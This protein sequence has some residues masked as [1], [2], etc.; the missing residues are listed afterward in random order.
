MAEL[1]RK[2]VTAGGAQPGS[3]LV[4]RTLRS[5]AQLLLARRTASGGGASVLILRTVAARPGAALRER[6]RH[7]YALRERLD[8]GWAARPIHLDLDADHPALTLT[9][10]GGELLSRR[11]GGP[12][13]VRA[14]LRV[15][16]GM[17]AALG[18]LH[19]RGLI[20]K[21]IQPGH[22]FVDVAAARA[23]L[24][25]FGLA[26][27]LP[28][29]QAS[30]AASDIIAGTLRYM[31]PEQTGRMNRSVDARSDLYA[32]GATFYE[33]LTGVAPF[34]VTDPAALMHAHLA[35]QPVAPGVRVPS[36]PGMLS[37]I[38]MKLLAKAAE[39]RYQTAAGLELDLRRCLSDWERQGSLDDF[40]LGT[41]DVPR[42]L[43]VPERLYG[44]EREVAALRAAF[45][46]VADQGRIELVLVH[47][48]AGI[49]KSSMVRELQRALLG[50]GGLFAAGK[51]DQYT[52]DVPLATLSQAL[53]GLLGMVIGRPEPER[54]V[55]QAALRTAVEPHGHFVAG[56][57][58][59]LES[60]IG[61]QPEDPEPS[62]Q[63]AP[64]RFHQVFRRFLQVFAQRAHPLVLFLDDLQWVD[65][66]TS[67]LL[68]QLLATPE[69]MHLLLVGA[70]RDGDGDGTGDAAPSH[71]PGVLARLEAMRGDGA[72][73]S[74][75]ALRPLDL[76]DIGWL[77]ADTLRT[78][79]HRV[80]ALAQ[81]VHERTGGNPFFTGQFIT[82]LADEQLLLY[83]ASTARWTWD[84]ARIDAL[85]EADPG[86]DGVVALMAQ[87]LRRL[88]AA[89]RAVLQQLACLGVQAETGALAT[90]ASCDADTLRA[91]LHP[92]VAAG[93][94]LQRQSLWVFSHDRVR[95]A[96]YA[97]IAPAARPRHHLQIARRM[98]AAMPSPD[99]RI[100]SV[101][102]IVDQLNRGAGAMTRQTEREQAAELNLMAAHRARRS[103]AYGSALGYLGAGIALL[104]DASWQR[105]HAM[106]FELHL[107][108]SECEL[109]AGLTAQAD[110]RLAGLLPRARTRIERAA[111]YRL[112]VV[113]HVLCS[114]YARAVAEA[115]ECLADFG[116]DLVPHPS[117]AQR[118]AAYADVL[119]RLGDRPIASL[120]ELPRAVDR[121]VEAAMAVLSELF[122]PACFT[123]ERL[124]FVHLCHMVR[125]SLS[126]GI[127]PG[128]AQ[129]FAWFGILLGR[130]YG[131]H[132]D[133]LQLA[134]LSQTLVTRHG[135]GAYEAKSLFSL[136]IAS[137]WTRP[138]EVAV[139]LARATFSTAAAQGD[140]AVACFA[141]HH[142]VN[143]LLLRGHPLDAVARDI[144]TGLAFVRKAGF[145]DVVDELLSQQRFVLALRGRTPSIKNW[146][147]DG[148]DTAAFEAALGPG[149]MPTMF[150]WH[151]LLRAQSLYIAGRP[152][153]A[154]DASLCAE[155]WLWSAVHVQCANQPYFAGLALAGLSDEEAA[156]VADRPQRLRGYRDQLAGWGSHAPATFADKVALLDAEIARL[157]RRPLDAGRLY[158][159]ATDLARTQGL[160]Q[161]EAIASELAAR[162]HAG[163]GLATVSE[164]YLRSARQ[165]YLRWGADAKVRQL[166]QTFAFLRHEPVTAGDVTPDFELSAERIDLAA[167]IRVSQALSGE[168]VLDRLIDTLLTAALGHAGAQR[169]LLVLADG[170]AW[171]VEAEAH[172][173]R[174]GE[175]V[176]VDFR[177]T[178]LAEHDM[179]TT[180]LQH[181]VRTRKR[182]LL[183]DAAVAQVLIP[184]GPDRLDDRA[185]RR[186]VLTLP[187]VRQ[188][189]LLGLL[190]LENNL[191][192]RVF[193]P[194]RLSLLEVMASQAAISLENARLYADLARENH[195]RRVAERENARVQA[196]LQDSELRFRRMADATPD[197]IWITELVPERVV[198]AS[199]S[200]ER[201]WGRKVEDL[202][203][204]PHLWI[205]SIHP[206]DRGRIGETFGQWLGGGAHGPWSAE[207]RVVRPDGAVRW[208]HERGVLISDG[209][210][211][212][213]SGISTDITDR[214]QAE[215]ALRES[216]ERFALA[217]AGANDGIYDWDIVSDQMFMS[218]QAQRLYGIEL[219]PTL[220]TRWEWMMLV[221]IHPDDIPVR[222][223]K[224][225]GYLEGRLPTCDGEW[226]MLHPDGVYR[227]LRIRGVCVRD[228]NGRATR[229]AGSVSD[230]DLQKRA[231]A[232]LQQ[233][234]RLE[235]V[236][237]LAGGIAHDFNNILGA[238][239]GFG[240]MALRGTRAGSRTRR[241][242][243]F[244]LTAGERGR[245]LVERILAFSRSGLTERV[246][247]H[248]EGVVQEVLNLLSASL[249]EGVRVQADLRAGA[250]AIRGD[251][252]QM[253]QVLMNLAT[254]ALQAMPDGGTLCIGLAP[255]R[256]AQPQV[257]STGTLAPGEYLVLS[258][259]DTGAGIG[260]ENLSR[261]FD[262]F[263]TT[264]DVGSG[265]G[266]GLSLVHGIVSEFG[267]ALD[268]HTARGEGS[269]FTVYLPRI[270]DMPLPVEGA[271]HALPR[272]AHE[273]VLV[274]DDEEALVR[275]T[276]DAL[277]GLGYVPVGFT[278]SEEALAA[279]AAHPDRFD[280]VL[281]DERMPGLSGAE[282]IRALRQVRPSVPVVWMSGYLG[283]AV[284]R[285]ARE[286][287]ADAVLGKPVARHELASALARVLDASP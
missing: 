41:A 33:M 214:R 245:A 74:A 223:E 1:Q 248:V 195:E 63:D 143:D 238:I 275:L 73:V 161:N 43:L 200:F 127:T 72:P 45:D 75:I 86:A 243:E 140:M 133:G 183:D 61:P 253:H 42:Q 232:A 208:I 101:F 282:L 30:A 35:Q 105:R 188:G 92:A 171:R 95:E 251:A 131:R 132:D 51:F 244:I 272:G 81:R 8:D 65:P 181:V 159:R 80:V 277:T 38:V 254:N 53:Q 128:S 48:P 22:F 130:F 259:A 10:P 220:R 199:P 40:V 284:V 20:H 115:I 135:F 185:G 227:W 23:W 28:R 27:A 217:V 158:Q 69:G 147:G 144:D 285:R 154:W 85:A 16:V 109:L 287:G 58:P 162:F 218:E 145:R 142:L 137:G 31:A 276:T 59:Q 179:P 196:A 212:R 286:A 190:Y 44:R 141:C 176:A 180:M 216:E 102:D 114:D 136:E 88:P 257:A 267:G 256:L 239:L 64:A 205:D 170:D 124:A 78:D 192:P 240:E 148:F 167:M 250:A 100:A 9:D 89:T 155:G 149:R 151:W 204:E 198:Y 186:S 93:L 116:I 278:S 12:W 209:Q 11:M 55:W 201:I 24:T 255:Q 68:V 7:E 222:S 271:P 270:D 21:D 156:R 60:L 6:L 178:A 224:I 49:G 236:G 260:P 113:M 169:G 229:L 129:G 18:Q 108:C 175:G 246:P 15:A 258:V 90:A 50:S 126:H 54:A 221:K 241:D 47:G 67:D 262:P 280:A 82:E 77:V 117:D 182:M 139:R 177:R 150:F 134:Q 207:F 249:P 25:G 118:D 34:Q 247:V 157:E 17:A 2:G 66:A 57:L 211:Q 269:T 268:V 174:N 233:S 146:D 56:L 70:C 191:A 152:G 91:L 121:D 29:E 14:A 94:L 32:L 215:A 264:K 110:P 281:T 172:T 99:A 194:E 39:D 83:D 203:R 237:T 52:R 123:D 103:A 79:T 210:V 98:L 252:T 213:V 120:S 230:I 122:A 263:F 84:T 173:R 189:Q 104:T 234:Q 71:S 37:R 225:F 96:A 19:A 231:E 273:Q 166:E 165:A 219:G 160:L 242:I 184:Q 87:K 168:I 26:S 274:V 36:L 4:D 206:A 3:R 76:A 107:V 163:E 5:D 202:Y 153:L 283:A 228:A 193:T 197:V 261:I 235:A 111:V 112:R 119:M 62:S 164:T 265:T 97:Q 226:R 138:L 279:F 187:L 125:L 13:P 106:C 266:L 46:R